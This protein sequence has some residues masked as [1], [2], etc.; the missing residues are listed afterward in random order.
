[1]PNL[2][3]A[4]T[5]PEGCHFT[6]TPLLSLTSLRRW[7]VLSPILQIEEA[8]FKNRWRLKEEQALK[9]IRAVAEA[10]KKNLS[11]FVFVSLAWLDTSIEPQNPVVVNPITEGGHFRYSLSVPTLYG[12][13]HADI[14]WVGFIYNPQHW[15]C[16]NIGI[17]DIKEFINDPVREECREAFLK[18]QEALQNRAELPT[19]ATVD[20]QL[21]WLLFGRVSL[22]SVHQVRINEEE[23]RQQPSR[24]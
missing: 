16:Q 4:R 14:E 22:H 19:Q 13:R 8:S 12:K 7:G 9:V 11:R 6:P 23:F 21:S 24:L 3:V 17:S 18:A 10:A 15:I 5:R 1:M 2:E 20:R